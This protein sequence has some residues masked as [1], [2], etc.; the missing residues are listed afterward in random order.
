LKDLHLKPRYA[1]GYLVLG[2]LLAE[3]GR[4]SEAREKLEKAESMFREMGMRYWLTKTQEVLER[5]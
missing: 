3:A 5:S 2:E 4:I 1:E